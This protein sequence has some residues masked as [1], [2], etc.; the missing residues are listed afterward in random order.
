MQISMVS[1]KVSELTMFCFRSCFFVKLFCYVHK[2]YAT[3]T[4]YFVL[5]IFELR[6]YMKHLYFLV[7]SHFWYFKIIAIVCFPHFV[8]CSFIIGIYFK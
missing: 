2:V 7:E 4:R 3:R 1:L 8:T 5:N 6:M